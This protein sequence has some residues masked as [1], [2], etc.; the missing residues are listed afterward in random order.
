MLSEVKDIFS[1][2]NNWLNFAEM[3][4]GVLI[5]LE[6]AFL[7]ALDSMDMFG[8][9]VKL[10]IE[11]M[12]IICMFPPLFSFIPRLNS[13]AKK[14]TGWV[15]Q[16]DSIIFYADIAKYEWEEYISLLYKRVQ[17][18]EK[19]WKEVPVIE[20]EYA[21]EIIVNARIALFKYKCFSVGLRMLLILLL[22]VVAAF[23]VS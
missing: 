2:V 19:E 11:I 20:Q 22:F 6:V 1:N 8:Q 9:E 3:K 5:A 18:V 14:K 4:N 7:A 10:G 17:S 16:P 21:K 23:L 13:Y 12:A 15:K